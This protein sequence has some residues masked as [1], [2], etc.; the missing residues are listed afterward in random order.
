MTYDDSISR[1]N[2]SR[3][4][5]HPLC[6][7]SVGFWR[8]LRA[9]HPRVDASF[10]DRARAVSLVSPL[11][12]PLHAAE[13]IVYGR[14][15]ANTTLTHPPIFVIGH[16][17]SGTTLLHNLLTQDPQFGFVSLFQTLAPGAFLVGRRTLQPILAL[18]APK[19]RP[20]DNVTIRLHF[21]SEEE[22][23]LAHLC[24]QSPYLGWYFPS[25]YAELFTK[26]G[27]MQGI[28]ADDKSE[29]ARAYRGLLTKATIAFAGRQLV[30]KNP[31]NT[32]RVQALREVFPGAKFIHI[33]RNPYD[34]FRA[35]LHLFREVLKTVS[36][37]DVA[38]AR[39]Q[40]LVLEF[41]P[42]M[43][44][45]YWEQRDAIP[46]GDHAEIRYDDFVAD[47]LAELERIYGELDL[48]GWSAALPHL[49]YFLGKRAG[50]QKNEYTHAPEHA[51]LVEQ[52]WA[53][54]F[55]RLGYDRIGA[56]TALVR[57]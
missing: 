50:F 30:L 16:W 56:R 1:Q 5:F 42:A 11:L 52:H 54:A 47:P 13:R 25:E 23:A 32:A 10:A 46:A 8:R 14:T 39:I 55:D 49:E 2:R 29:W 17:R 4:V 28:S 57:A 53:F 21:P 19:T 22:F 33:H 31:V 35:T 20:M 45:A 38:E 3:D 27:L 6:F 37:Q 44:N 36:L 40:E 43:M 48:N 15:V 24:P 7:N 34:V 41:Y 18:R 51:S 12:A 9:L 26:Y